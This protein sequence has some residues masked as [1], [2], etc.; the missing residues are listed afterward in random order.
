MSA[1]VRISYETEEELAA[2]R[3]KLS[4]YM[5]RVVLEPR[6][7]RYKRAYLRLKNIPAGEKN[8]TEGTNFSC[9]STEGVV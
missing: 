1:I 4:I 6:K 9:I 5:S 2:I 3:D 8:L 7:G